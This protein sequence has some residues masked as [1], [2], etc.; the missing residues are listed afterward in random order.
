M[1][2]SAK[3]SDSLHDIVIT[4]KD[5]ETSLDAELTKINSTI[6]F[7]THRI[8]KNDEYN[9]L[10]EISLLLLLLIELSFVCSLFSNVLKSNPQPGQKYIGLEYSPLYVQK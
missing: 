2:S 9:Q 8:T 6:Y 7:L 5:R 4:L 1:L 10:L 3:I